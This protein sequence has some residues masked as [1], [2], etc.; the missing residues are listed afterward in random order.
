MQL[1]AVVVA[2][3][4][5]L[6]AWL[7]T[8]YFRVWCCLTS[9]PRKMA[10]LRHFRI[11]C[12]TVCSSLRW[13]RWVWGGCSLSSTSSDD[14]GTRSWFVVRWAGVRGRSRS[15]VVSWDSGCNGIPSPTPGS[16]TGCR[17]VVFSSVRIQILQHRNNKAISE[18]IFTQLKHFVHLNKI[19]LMF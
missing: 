11:R 6:W 1:S 7:M 9:L 3:F 10:N 12:R 5:H 16:G 13:G 15:V 8:S 17:S 19:W 14:S 4:V 2:Q 18:C